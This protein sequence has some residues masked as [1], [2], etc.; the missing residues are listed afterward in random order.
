VFSVI[1]A[2]GGM[3]TPSVRIVVTE[4]S[5][6]RRSQRR[7]DQSRRRH[8]RIPRHLDR[9][10]G[11]ARDQARQLGQA[12]RAQARR[13]VA[14]GRRTAVAGHLMRGCGPVHVIAWHIHG[15]GHLRGCSA[16]QRVGRRLYGHHQRGRDHGQ[17]HK[18]VQ[19]N[20]GQVTQRHGRIVAPP[21]SRPRAS[22]RLLN[23]SREMRVRLLSA[24]TSLG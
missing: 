21:V 15:G 19:S 16:L 20:A 8:R 10:C 23:P 14:R 11:N 13:Q 18:P 12:S 24:E 5:R 1:A 4:R 6:D 2:R 7:I 3:R 22:R 17:D 9:P